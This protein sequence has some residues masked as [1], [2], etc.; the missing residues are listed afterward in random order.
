MSQFYRRKEPKEKDEII[1]NDCFEVI[2]NNAYSKKI[3]W[4]EVVDKLAGNHK[5][6]L[7]EKC[8]SIRSI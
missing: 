7:C 3:K 8:N 4:F 2:C 5:I 1:C 6:A